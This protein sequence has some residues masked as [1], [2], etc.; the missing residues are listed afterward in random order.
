[1]QL[2]GLSVPRDQLYARINERTELMIKA[3]LVE[4]TH[5]V[6]EMGVQPTAQS[7]NTV[8]YKE[9]ISYLRKEITK[10][11][12]TELIQQSTR[13]FAKRQYTWFRGEEEIQW[14]HAPVDRSPEELVEEL[15]DHMSRKD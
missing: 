4:E 14:M 7:L 15:L 12:M 1:M 8:G 9:V 2:Y 3:G 5:R 13:R 6:L 11:R 10:E